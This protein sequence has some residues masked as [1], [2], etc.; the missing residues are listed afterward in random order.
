MDL[1]PPGCKDNMC[2]DH[3][4]CFVDEKASSWIRG[5]QPWSSESQVGPRA[6]FGTSTSGTWQCDRR[7]RKPFPPDAALTECTNKT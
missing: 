3:R 1:A 5:F 6:C 2:D 7:Q 4:R